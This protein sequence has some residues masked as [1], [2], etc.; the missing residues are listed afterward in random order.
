[1]ATIIVNENTFDR[2]LAHEILE[3]EMSKKDIV[4]AVKSDRD[5]ENRIKD[6]V[7]NSLKND[8]DTNKAL[9][10]WAKTDRDFEKRVKNIVADVLIKYNKTLWQRSNFLDSEIRN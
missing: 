9:K 5:I 1:M 7:R 4:D 6:I 2:L 3:E 10:D 8:S